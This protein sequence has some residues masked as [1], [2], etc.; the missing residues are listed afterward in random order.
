MTDD[1]KVPLLKK[2]KH[3]SDEEEEKNNKSPKNK[4]DNNII[5]EEDE[6]NELLI[7]KVDKKVIAKNKMIGKIYFLFFIQLSI[8]F[9]FIYYAFHSELFTNLLKN[10]KQMF[11]LS[12]GC[13]GLIF[14]SAYK[15]KI[16]LIT[17]PFNYFCFLIFTI[18]ISFIICKITI[19]FSFKTIAFLWALTLIMILSL[20]AYAYNSKKEIT[21]ISSVIF[22]SI[23]LV[24]FSII[25]KFVAEIPI[26]DML[27][28]LL[29][30]ISLGV[31]LVYDVNC[32][33][34]DK[35]VGDKEYILVN[36]FLYTNVFHIFLK[37]V[38]LISDHFDLSDV[39]DKNNVLSNIKG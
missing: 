38:K 32:L 25:I 20:S 7:E 17:V 21:I 28:M 14:Y 2:I 33:I 5:E 13:T 27:F 12:I 16:L 10:N 8:T 34:E 23:I 26:F 19:L 22:A 39:D 4:E 11:L 3:N 24:S 6:E 9:L 1:I 15:L 35:N 29:C 30:L 18:S 31:Y 37:L 36:V